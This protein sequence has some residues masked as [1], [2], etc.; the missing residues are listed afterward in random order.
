MLEWIE[1]HQT[2]SW[3]LAAASAVMFLGSL[4][5]IPFLVVRIPEDYFVRP[6]R[7]HGRWEHEHPVVRGIMVTL[8]NVLGAVFVLAGI[9]ML[10]LPGQGVIC[11]LI[12][13]MFLDFPGKFRLERWVADRGPVSGAMN[14]M[15]KKGGRP[16]LRHPEEPDPPAPDRPQ[17]PA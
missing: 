9:A 17:D 14:W 7:P 16:P 8:K 15:R 11:I 6:Q 3:W 1:G 5:A 2:I 13:V 10:V 4:I 12:G